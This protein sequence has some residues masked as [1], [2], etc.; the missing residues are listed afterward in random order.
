MKLKKLCAQLKKTHVYI[1]I[2]LITI[3]IILIFS[4]AYLVTDWIKTTPLKYDANI[5]E[6]VSSF[7]ENLP[8]VLTLDKKAYDQK[9]LFLANNPPRATSS[10]STIT[11]KWPVKTVYPNA[12][13]LL[14]FNR[15]VA[16]YGNFYSSKMGVL[17]EYPPDEMKEKLLG[18]VAKWK[19]ADPET[20]VIPAIHYI[21]ST[22]QG[23]PGDDGKYRIRMPDDQIQ[24]AIALANDVHGLVFLDVQVG[25]SNVQTEIPLLEKYLKL[26]NVHLAIDPEFSMKTGAKPGTV[27]G[28]MDATDINY[29]ANFLAKVVKENNLPP[30]ILIVHRFTQ[31]MVTNYEN[32]TPLPE[33]QIVMDMDGWG[34]PPNK[35]TTYKS[36]IEKE[37]VQFTGFKLFYKNDVKAVGSRMLT[38]K[39]LLDLRPRPSYIQYQ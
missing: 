9:M 6:A 12:G 3:A 11:Y 32:I 31:N 39:E 10:T 28:T 30:K 2:P 21:V 35:I 24:K 26:P 37:P 17:G 8:V 23:Y 4:V 36:F 7:T 16:Y 1:T 27:I 38:P 15:I 5:S 25:L 14:P 33:V 22:A 19:M 34:P 29:A 20:P 13:A 18:E